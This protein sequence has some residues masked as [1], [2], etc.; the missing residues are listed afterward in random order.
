MEVQAIARAT[1]CKA[2]LATFQ[3]RGA[4]PNLVRSLI[5]DA[6]CKTPLMYSPLLS[7]FLFAPTRVIL[8]SE[9]HNAALHEL[10]DNPDTIGQYSHSLRACPS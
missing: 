3:E 9:A 6:I 1:L 8:V 10:A 5:D 7:R 2:F 4:K